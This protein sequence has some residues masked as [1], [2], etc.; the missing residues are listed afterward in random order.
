MARKYF[1]T[2]T[3]GRPFHRRR[4]A[5]FANLVLVTQRPHPAFSLSERLPLRPGIAL[6]L[7]GGFARGYAHLGVLQVFEEQKIPISCLVGSSI[8]SILAAAY[9]SGAPLPRI[10][11]KC[12]EIRFRDFAKWRVSRFGLASNERLGA[13]VQRFF[14][15]KQFE[16]LKIPTGIVATD[17]G[18][19]D[20]VL[21]KE[22]SISDAIRAS[23]AFPGLF[24]PVHIGTR[25]LAD[26][27][28]V[29]PVP[30]RVAREM[31]AQ[32]V[33]GVSVGTHDGQRGA[34]T[35]IFQVVSRAVSAA[36]KHQLEVWERHADL[37]L[38]PNVQSLAWDD[39]HRID[40]AIEAGAKAALAA[41]PQLRK[42]ST[43]KIEEVSEFGKQGEL[44]LAISSQ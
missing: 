35:N 2:M 25:Y 20:A 8:G 28:L 43:P 31:G 40:E 18:T 16:D 13:L 41:L 7:G 39:F 38:R 24:E 23:C 17:L 44:L 11:A 32:T 5:Y 1:R 14:D 12:S 21:F 34:P 22:G 29:A 26:G 3:S 9:A 33:I 37:V 4:K 27:G 10:I 36:Q 6:A 19:G 30:T 15:S 42:L